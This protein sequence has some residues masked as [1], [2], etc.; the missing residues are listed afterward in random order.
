MRFPFRLYGMTMVTTMVIK[1]KSPREF[2]VTTI[3]ALPLNSSFLRFRR[4]IKDNR[5]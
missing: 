3:N 2:A 1:V 5:N 4:F